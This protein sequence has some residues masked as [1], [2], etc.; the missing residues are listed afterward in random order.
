MSIVWEVLRGVGIAVGAL[1]VLALV[2]W[3]GD[4]EAK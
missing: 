2:Y 1:L 4:F 3:N